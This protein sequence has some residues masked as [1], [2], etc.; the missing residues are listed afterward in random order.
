MSP[1]LPPIS[2]HLFP[3][4]TRQGEK[5]K[6]LPNLLVLSFIV[7]EPHLWCGRRMSCIGPALT[8]QHSFMWLPI[9][10]MSLFCLHFVIFHQISV[11]NSNRSFFT[12]C[13]WIAFDYPAQSSD[14]TVT[15][16]DDHALLDAI[17]ITQ[18]TGI[19]L[20]SHTLE[21]RKWCEKIRTDFYECFSTI[22]SCPFILDWRE[23]IW[24]LQLV[25]R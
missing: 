22:F 25:E 12:A 6:A 11:Y 21:A 7:K 8:S 4:Q 5:Y 17:E 15:N 16:D 14:G 9:S 20:V 1:R 23:F 10:S 18:I 2:G 24:L 13:R 19:N 3:I